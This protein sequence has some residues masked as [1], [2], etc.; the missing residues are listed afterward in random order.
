MHDRFPSYQNLQGERRKAP[1]LRFFRLQIVSTV[2]QCQDYP[3]QPVA[4]QVP[5]WG[6]D[7]SIMTTVRRFIDSRLAEKLRSPRP[8]L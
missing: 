4:I 8:C 2:T 6:S 7:I 3:G 5:R 1:A